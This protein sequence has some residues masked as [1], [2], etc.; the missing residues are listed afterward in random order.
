MNNI[1][2]LV[3]KFEMENFEYLGTVIHDG[4]QYTALLPLKENS[5]RA[6]LFICDAEGI[7]NR[8]ADRKTVTAVSREF[9]KTVIDAF[10]N[11]IKLRMSA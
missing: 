7:Y 8:I 4:V 9:R 10:M 2:Q 1:I 5:S 11:P 3:D 6:S